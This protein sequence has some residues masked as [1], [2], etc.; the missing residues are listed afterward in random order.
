MYLCY[1]LSSCPGLANVKS[2][3]SNKSSC[4]NVGITMG[5]G[6]KSLKATDLGTLSPHSSAW[7]IKSP[8]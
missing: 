6:Q 3:P 1:H 2:G 5:C 7:H 4:K 8:P